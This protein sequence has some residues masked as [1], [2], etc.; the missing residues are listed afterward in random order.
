MANYSTEPFT[1]YR[2]KV[3]DGKTC[4]MYPETG[5]PYYA[6]FQDAVSILTKCL[7]G[8][9]QDFSFKRFEI[10]YESHGQAR[11]YPQQAQS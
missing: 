9:P 2:I 5:K 4:K 8:H 10:V 11:M 3:I 1:G 6:T 7:L